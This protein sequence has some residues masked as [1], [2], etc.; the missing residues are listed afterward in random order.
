[1][2]FYR[3]QPENHRTEI[4]YMILPEF[5][6]KGY[7]TEAIGTMLDYAFTV[8]NFHSIEAVIDP[9]NI[10]SALSIRKKN[11]VKAHFKENEFYNG[12]FIDSVHYGI[13]KRF[14]K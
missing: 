3:T 10:G 11:F 6:G 13:L 14:F 4:G 9:E 1:M 7:V 5:E 8:Q 2:G 12:M